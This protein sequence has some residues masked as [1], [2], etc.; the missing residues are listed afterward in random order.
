MTAA[1]AI[2]VVACA[3]DYILLYLNIK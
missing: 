3:I 1:T 2:V